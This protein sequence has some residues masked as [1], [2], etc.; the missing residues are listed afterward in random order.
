MKCQKKHEAAGHSSITRSSTV[1]Q[2]QIL[3]SI[4]Y[5][6]KTFFSSAISEILGF[7]RTFETRPFNNQQTSETR[8]LITP[9]TASFQTD[10]QTTDVWVS[11][12]LS[13]LPAKLIH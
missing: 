7:H 12:A 6:L 10:F 9:P 8:G 2:A 3:P 4:R 1:Q 13:K 5:F 11:I